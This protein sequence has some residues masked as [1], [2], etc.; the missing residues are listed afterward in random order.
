MDALRVGIRCTS[1]VDDRHAATLIH[2]GAR[3]A[4]AIIS[5]VARARETANSV[6]TRCI[7]VT[8]VGSEITLVDVC[9]RL[10]VTRVASDTR[11]RERSGRVGA[12]TTTT[13]ARARVGAT[14]ALIDVCAAHTITSVPHI[15]CASVGTGCVRACR[16]RSAHRRAI[17]PQQVRKRRRRSHW[18]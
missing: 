10:A 9:T 7:R 2:V 5:T 4:S 13:A 11:T 1:A 17:Q 12:R 14:R 15:A 6:G 18:A 16:R 8:A 3:D